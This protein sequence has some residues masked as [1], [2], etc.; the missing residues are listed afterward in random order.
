MSMW[1]GPTGFSLLLI[2]SHANAQELLEDAICLLSNRWHIEFEIKNQ[3]NVWYAWGKQSRFTVGESTLQRALGDLYSQELVTFQKGPPDTSF[4]SALR[5]QKCK[6]KWN[7]PDVVSLPSDDTGGAATPVI[8][9]R[10][11]AR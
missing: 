5:Y 8:S 1:S 7:V 3:D 11:K 4:D 9:F 10:K 6:R 2:S